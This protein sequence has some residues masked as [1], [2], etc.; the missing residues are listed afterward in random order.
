MP[1]VLYWCGLLLLL[2]MKPIKTP[3]AKADSSPFE[4]YILQLALTLHIQ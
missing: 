2:K 4:L 3:L 1:T